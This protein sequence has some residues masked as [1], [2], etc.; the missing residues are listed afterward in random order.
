MDV[1]A[2]K[3]VNVGELDL[4]NAG[5]GRHYSC[6]IDKQVERQ[7][8]SRERR[9]DRRA[10]VLFGNI[11]TDWR[12]GAA[13]GCIERGGAFRGADGSEHM[14]ATRDETSAQLESV[15]ATGTCDQGRAEHHGGLLLL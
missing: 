11:H 7:V 5:T 15:S 14:D 6:I 1:H 12:A 9:G 3:A 4:L 13:S 10:G 8:A 2:H